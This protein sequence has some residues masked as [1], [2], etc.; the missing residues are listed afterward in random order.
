MKLHKEGEIKTAKKPRK[1]NRVHFFQNEKKK[2][3]TRGKYREHPALIF[4][5][6]GKQY[7]AIIFTS[8][9]TTDGIKNIKLL[10]NVDPDSIDDCYG[11]PYRGPR[12][13]NDFQP[14]KKPYRVHK[15]DVSRIKQLKY[16]EKRKK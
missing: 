14:P 6:S 10:H 15:D 1:W 2:Q 13:K 12:S 9:T 16:S 11:V 7:K 8:C 3:D 5:K 4:E